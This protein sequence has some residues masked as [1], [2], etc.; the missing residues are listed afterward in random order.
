ML[1]IAGQ[2][3]QARKEAAQQA[4]SEMPLEAHM[5]YYT[6]QGMDRKSAMKQVAADRGVGKRE[7]YKQLL[8]L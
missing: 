5:A 7:I 6:D 1:V 4:W 2:D 3:V 8:E